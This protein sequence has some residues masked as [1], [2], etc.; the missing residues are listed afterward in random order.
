MKAVVCGAGKSTRNLLSRL[1]DRWRVTLVDLSNQRLSELTAQFSCVVKAVAGDASSPV[2]LEEAE[3]AEADYVLALTPNDKVNLVV[4][5]YARERNIRHIMAFVNDPESETAFRNLGVY[6][7]LSGVVIGGALY[8]FLQD[9]RIRVFP[10][11]HGQGELVELEVSRDNWIAGTE[12]D[13]LSDPEWHL[14]GLFRDGA[15]MPAAPGLRI[16][17]GDRIILLGKRNFFRTVC[18]LIAC[19]NIPFPL[20]W[21]GGLLLVLG[22]EPTADL[23]K[24]VEEGMYW[25]ANSRVHFVTVLYRET[26]GDP[27][28]LF[29]KWSGRFDL[30]FKPVSENPLTKAEAI[31]RDENIGLV[32]LRPFEK[33]FFKSLA[34]PEIIALAHELP[35]PM[36]VARHSQP[37]QRILVP[38]RATPMAERALETAMELAEHMAAETDAAVVQEPDFI[39]T[40]DDAPQAPLFNRVRELSH[41]HKAR[42]GEV[43]RQGNPVREMTSLSEEYD[44]MVLGSTSKSKELLTPHVG[45]LLSERAVCS[46][47][48]IAR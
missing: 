44:L 48:V 20:E 30:R 45:E 5:T 28:P 25:A 31:C 32:V 12:T 46:V 18:S 3:T 4:A 41:I 38:F 2:V 6:T 10:V 39:H 47:M 11:S 15:L 29:Q 26:E 14:A 35:C 22:D 24:T 36:V 16:E 23:K 40:D 1:G 9:P 43:F 37:Y 42:V 19:A 27:E 21:G 17:G 33:S 13:S 34:K 8:H 7:L